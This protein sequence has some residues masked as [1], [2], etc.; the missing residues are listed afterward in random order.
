MKTKRILFITII[1]IVFTCGLTALKTD[2]KS[3]E[4]SKH[5]NIY[6]TL[7]RDINMFYVD[8]I[9]PGDLVT[10]SIK[11]MLKSLDPYTVYYPESEMEDVKLMTTGEY[12]GIGSIISKKGDKVIIREPYKNSPAAKAGLLPG[13]IILSIDG[14]ST[15][16]KNTDDVST[17]LK[18]QPGKEITIKVQREY[19]D[20]PLEKK[21]I[22]E[23][24]GRASCRERV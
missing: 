2:D 24:I 19:Q 6:A 4:I 10:T 21:A 9:N 20:K 11:A 7:F 18:G 1:A 22:R 12:A 15:K 5:L 8:E 23:K 14:N 13:D 17:M 16:G 3:F